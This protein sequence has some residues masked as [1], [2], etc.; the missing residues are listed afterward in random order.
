M[1]LSIPKPCHEDWRKMTACEQGRFC[2]SCNKTVIDFTSK[3]DQEIELFFKR[4]HSAKTCGRVKS[5]QLIKSPH[6]VKAENWRRAAI[7]VGV[8]FSLLSCT[9]VDQNLQGKIS[10]VDSTQSTCNPDIEEEII[11]TTGEIEPLH[12][13]IDSSITKMGEI[14]TQKPE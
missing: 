5:S 4:E 2:S 14:E 12:L 3:S 7:M 11:T 6:Y 8:V 1:K 9:E 10:I 13:Q